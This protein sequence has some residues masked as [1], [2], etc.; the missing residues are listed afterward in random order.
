MSTWLRPGGRLLC[1]VGHQE[2]T[3]TEDHWLGVDGGTMYW[4][5]ADEKTYR[6]WLRETGFRVAETIFIPEGRGGHV[7]LLA[8]S[9]TPEEGNRKPAPSEL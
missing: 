5:H 2:W 7:A 3:G 9:R 1:T 4:S 6:L 8:E